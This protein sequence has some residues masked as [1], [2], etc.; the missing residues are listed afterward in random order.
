MDFTQIIEV[1]STLGFPIACVIALGWFVL[2]ILRKATED[3]TKIMKE[4]QDKCAARENKLSEQIA[5]TQKINRD[6][7]ATITLYA[8]RLDNIQKDVSEIKTSLT[9]LTHKAE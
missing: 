4:I 1:I 2:Y 8:E 3:S 6:A 7:I 9:I 5:A